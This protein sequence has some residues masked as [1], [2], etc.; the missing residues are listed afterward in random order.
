MIQQGSPG[1]VITITSVQ[2]ERAWGWDTIYGSMKAALRRL[3]MSQARELAPHQIRVNAIA[4]GFIDL[5]LSVGE[6]GER[7]DGFSRRDETDTLLC[8]AKPHVLLVATVNL[9]SHFP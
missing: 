1:A 4:P 6:P 5:R 3:V 8:P 2:Q 7:Y 9:V